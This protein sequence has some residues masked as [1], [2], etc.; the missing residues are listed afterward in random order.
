MILAP[1]V[2]CD[3]CNNGPL[4]QLDRTIC[5]FLPVAMQRT[6]LGIPSKV[7]KIPKARF[8]EGTM[9]HLPGLGVADPTLSMRSNGRRGLIREV[10]QLPGGRVALQM[11][12]RGGRRMT[13]RYASDLSRA[14]LKSALECAWLDHHSRML[15]TQFDHIRDAVLGTPRD[16]FLAILL[17][18]D[19]NDQEVRL[20]YYLVPDGEG[21]RMP[22]FASYYGMYLATD[23]RLASPA[24]EL[25]KGLAAVI[26]FSASD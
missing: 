14:V 21:L 5:D 6:I 10:G 20:T 3:R 18:G 23:S 4:A 12:V 2:V 16:G 15:Q 19:P 25:P 26:T 11:R 1:G 7:G 22:V 8:N 13:S 24:A 9:E 17:K